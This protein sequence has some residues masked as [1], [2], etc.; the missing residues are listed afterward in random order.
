M[1]PAKRG[2][3]FIMNNETILAVLQER[4]ANTLVDTLGVTF[5]EL[6]EDYLIAKMPV[7]SAVHQVD[8]VLHGGATAALAET[9]GSAACAIFCKTD[10]VIMR[11]IEVSANHVRGVRSGHVYAKATALHKGKTMQHWQISITNDEGQLVS[12]C[13][14]TTIILP[15]KK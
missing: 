5:V 3:S 14:L 8:G 1:R 4:C 11:G 7:T 13:K 15:N 9:V 6:G 10:D 2:A 12:S